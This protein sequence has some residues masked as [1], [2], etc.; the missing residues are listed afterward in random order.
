MAFV[1]DRKTYVEPGSNEEVR[2]DKINADDKTIL[3]SIPVDS[4][5]Q[6]Q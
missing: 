5:T 1:T 3:M 6:Y 4:T 2:S